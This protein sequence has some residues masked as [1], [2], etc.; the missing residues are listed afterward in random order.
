MK[1]SAIFI[2]VLLLIQTNAFGGYKSN[3]SS[4][5]SSISKFKPPKKPEEKPKA[6][7][8][9]PPPPNW[10]EDP[11][12]KSV[13]QGWN[14]QPTLTK[15]EEEKKSGEILEQPI[16]LTPI[17]WYDLVIDKQSMT[18]KSKKGW[19]INFTK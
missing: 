9:P 12:R 10:K 4:K 19:F 1:L 5:Q 8:P 7:N 2:L 6:Q 15:K 16:Q 3:K 11:K 17:N 13:K 18:L 14:V